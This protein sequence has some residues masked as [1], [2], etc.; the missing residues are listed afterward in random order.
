MR[1]RLLALGKATLGVL[2]VYA[3]GDP[4]HVFEGRL[5][6]EHRACLGTTASVDVVEGEGAGNC[7][8]TCLTQPLA[9]GG[10][11]IYVSTMCA[12]YPYAF[13]ASGTDPA[14]TP[15]LDA[16]ARG[17]TCLLDGG[18]SSPPA[19]PPVDAGSD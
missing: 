14:C 17:D 11:A 9:D 13:D 5:F 15:A 10:R 1:R 12:P 19:P 18:S 3:C 4:S 16:L 7:G 6:V 2:L 8:P